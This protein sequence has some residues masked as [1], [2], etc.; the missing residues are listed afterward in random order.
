LLLCKL[1]VLEHG[2]KWNLL[3][4]G[5]HLSGWSPIFR[6]TGFS[7]LSVFR[8]GKAEPLTT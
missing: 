1:S 7:Q 2:R 4:L 5:P 6:A 3:G 8:A